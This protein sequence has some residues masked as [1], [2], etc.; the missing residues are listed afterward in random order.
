MPGLPGRR[1]DLAHLA[2]CLLGADGRPAEAMAELGAAFDAGAWWHR[3]IL[4][5]DDDLA[6]LGALAG[7]ADLVE[8]SH[9]RASAAAPVRRPPLIHRPAGPARGVLVALH[10]AGEDADDAATSWQSGVDA[11]FVLLALDSSQRNTPTYR[12][13]PDPAVGMADIAAALTSLTDADRR[14]PLIAAGFSA[15]GRQAIQWALAGRPGRPAGFI[16]MAPAVGPAQVDPAD[17]TRAVARGVTGTAIIGD[18]DDDVRDDAVPAID[19]L[20][21]AGMAC[22]LETVPGL[23][24]AFPADFPHRLAQALPDSLRISR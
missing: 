15:G 4:T 8:R 3:R 20:S 14:L 16:A 17:L 12:S 21:R 6:G 24:H 10:G 5:E 9:A 18:E 23:G 19:A 13:W 7:F 1:A 2:A 22:R 11:G